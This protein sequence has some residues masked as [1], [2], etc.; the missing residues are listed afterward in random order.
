[1]APGTETLCALLHGRAVESRRRTFADVTALAHE[2]GRRDTHDP[3]AAQDLE[4]HVDGGEQILCVGDRHRPLTHL[5][6]QG[7]AVGDDGLQ[8]HVPRIANPLRRPGPV[9]ELAPALRVRRHGGVMAVT[10]TVLQG[11]GPRPGHLLAEAEVAIPSDLAHL[12][13]LRSGEC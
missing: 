7:F 2:S 13:L 4:D 3:V 1:M 8:G 6:G 11:L 12:D 9:R 10:V 5:L